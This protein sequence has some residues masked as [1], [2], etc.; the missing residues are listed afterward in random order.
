MREEAAP[1]TEKRC[2]H[3]SLLL[4]SCQN[5][6]TFPILCPHG[7]SSLLHS[8]PAVAATCNDTSGPSQLI[9]CLSGQLP[10]HSPCPRLAL[11]ATPRLLLPTAMSLTRQLQIV[12]F[13]QG[14]PSSSPPSLVTPPLLLHP[15][16]PTANLCY[17]KLS[18]AVL[19]LSLILRV[20]LSDQVTPPPSPTPTACR[21]WLGRQWLSHPLTQG[22][23]G[24]LTRNSCRTG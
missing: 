6:F 5:C 10:A 21:T 20:S 9:Y 23:A 3:P 11:P 17:V 7:G 8:L 2:H 24:P 16:L 15:L 18:S 1:G 19:I 13:R 22:S 4:K 12:F 14:I